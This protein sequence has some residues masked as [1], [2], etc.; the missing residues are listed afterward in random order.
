MTDDIKIDKEELNK[1]IDDF[2]KCFKDSLTVF[3]ADFLRTGIDRQH[4]GYIIRTME[5]FDI[6]KQSNLILGETRVYWELTNFGHEILRADGWTK[7]LFDKAEDK[8]ANRQLVK[9]STRANQLNFWLLVATAVFSFLALCISIADF[10]VHKKE[11][12]LAKEVL[13]LQKE[14][15]QKQQ[16]ESLICSCHRCKANRQTNPKTDSLQRGVK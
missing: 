15:S 9:A 4:F 1:R 3:E 11:L 12:K 8:E 2:V 14:E 7:Y 5:K 13:Q 16:P 6:I 10:M